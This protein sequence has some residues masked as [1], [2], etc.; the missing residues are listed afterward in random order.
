MPLSSSVAG[1][2]GADGANAY[3]L[4]VANGFTGN[5]ADWL[6]SLIGD[7]GDAGADST[8]PGPK[9][10]TG[11]TGDA[12][13]D[14]TVPGPK[15][16]TGD[17]GADSTV[18]GPAGSVLRNGSGVPSNSLGVNGD[19]YLDDATGNVYLRTAGTY[20]VTANV[21]GATGPAGDA[22]GSPFLFMGA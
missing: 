1:T 19:Y 9:G 12:G 5:E 6:L 8:V 20:S 7:T 16:D 13:A 11:D 14:S 10:D 15:G 17:A 18:A 4:A 22:G 21:K 2:A 3:E